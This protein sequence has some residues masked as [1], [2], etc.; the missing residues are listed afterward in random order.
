MALTLVQRGTD[1]S[2]TLAGSG[3]TIGRAG[4]DL[5]LEGAAIEAKHAIV[6]SDERGWR[7]EARAPMGSGGIPLAPG[8]SRLLQAGVPLTIGDVIVEVIDPI[9]DVGMRTADLA[10][11]VVGGAEGALDRWSVRVLE[12]PDRG[13]QRAI[14]DT[15]AIGRAPEAGLVLADPKTS[16]EHAVVRVMNGVVQVR[17]LGAAGGTF[18]GP[19]RLAPERWAIWKRDVVLGVG[20]SVLACV[21][22]GIERIVDRLERM[23]Q[24]DPRTPHSAAEQ[25]PEPRE[26]ASP[27]EHAPAPVVEVPSLERP[28]SGRLV[29][30]IPIVAAG[31]IIAAALAFL[32]WILR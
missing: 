30:A 13:S 27:P 14:D 7:V 18:L 4:C 1:R 10:L 19:V 24:A 29:A 15:L 6:H 22:P 20:A 11:K 3:A 32:I 31:V 12:G 16:R 25:A 9:T 5:V 21:P 23:P 17:D 8:A 2:V 26:I 28:R